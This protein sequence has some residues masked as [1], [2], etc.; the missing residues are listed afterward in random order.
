MNDNK[1]VYLFE[2]GTPGLLI[3]F[4]AN[5]AGDFTSGQ[6]Y[7]HKADAQNKWIP[8]END[9]D[10]LINLRTI[11]FKRGATMY[12]RLEWGA[13][14]KSNG[15]IYI[16]ETGNDNP[17]TAFKTGIGATGNIANHLIAAYKN[18]YQIVNGTSFPVPML[19]L[20][21]QFAMVLLKITMVEF[22]SLIQLQ[23]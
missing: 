1:T 11:A 19:R 22:W 12:T 7:A 17:G 21:I 6:L 23:V 5:V 15:K 14:N 13:V 8:I 20:V 4:V 16:T 2:D 9:L 10:T 18:R 3:K